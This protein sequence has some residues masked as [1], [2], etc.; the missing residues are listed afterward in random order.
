LNPWARRCLPLSAVL[1]GKPCR[2]GAF[3]ADIAAL[4]GVSLAW[5]EGFLLGFAL[6]PEPGDAGKEGYQD[7]RA[8]RLKYY[9]PRNNSAGTAP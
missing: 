8:F 9:P 2:T 1:I 6:S 5:V 7:G 3:E 4:L